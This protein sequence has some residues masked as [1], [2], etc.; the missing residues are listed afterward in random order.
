MK[1]LISTDH[2]VFSL[3]LATRHTN[4]R[5]WTSSFSIGTLTMT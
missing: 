2:I 5:R 1:I 4:H 3:H